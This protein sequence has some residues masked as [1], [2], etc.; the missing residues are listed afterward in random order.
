M[1]AAAEPTFQQAMEI[2]AQWLALWEAGELSEE[3]LADRVGELVASRE[4]YRLLV[5]QASDIVYRTDVN[6]YFT[7]CNPTAA[8]ITA[9]ARPS[10]S[11][12]S[13]TVRP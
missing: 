12:M 3:V 8:R 11:R 7:F 4:D 5:D 9:S 2:T 10:A 1:S 13:S 6:G